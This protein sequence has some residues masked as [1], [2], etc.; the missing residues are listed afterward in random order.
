MSKNDIGRSLSNDIEGEIF[1][2]TKSLEVLDLS[3]NNII[4]ISES[5]FKNMAQLQILNLQNNQ[6]SIWR[7]KINHIK[8]Y[9]IHQSKTKQTNNI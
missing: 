5:I 4:A 3:Y 2:N 1:S 7:V 8:K 6:I 9:E